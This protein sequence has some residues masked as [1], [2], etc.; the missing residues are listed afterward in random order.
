[1][2]NRLFGDIGENMAAKHLKKSGYKILGRNYNTPFGEL[3]I[4][5]TKD[6]VLVF[7]EVK[8]RSSTRFGTAAEAVTYSKQR[9]VIKSAQYYCMKEKK[10]Q[11]LC[12]FDV[13]AIDGDVLTHIENAFG[14]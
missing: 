1:M 5:A 11:C 12:R 8:R 7:V 9:K 10:L 4:I 14:L 3:D 2:L 6:E 13:V